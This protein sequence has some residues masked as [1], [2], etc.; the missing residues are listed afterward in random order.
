MEKLLTQ[1]LMFVLV[2][3]NIKKYLY[4]PTLHGGDGCGDDVDNPH[5]GYFDC[6]ACNGLFV[7]FNKHGGVGTSWTETSM[8]I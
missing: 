7:F 8:I 6:G 1:S 2:V 4:S 3:V 5:D